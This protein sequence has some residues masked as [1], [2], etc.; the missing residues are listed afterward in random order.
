M[1]YQQMLIHRCDIFHEAAQALSA[2]RFGIPADK[3]QPVISYPD[4][5]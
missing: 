5:P 4:T 3:L 2:G 1:S